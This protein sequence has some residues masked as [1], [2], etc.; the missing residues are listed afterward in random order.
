MWFPNWPIQRRLCLRPELRAN[1]YVLF[2][3]SARGLQI[4]ACSDI[5]SARGIRP[6]IPL[7]EARGLCEG[8]SRETSAT[9]QR[10]GVT[11]TLATDAMA[12][13]AMATNPSVT[14]TLV[15]EPTD[16]IA[17]RKALQ[18]LALQCQTYS[19]LVGVEESETPDSLLLE[20]TGCEAHFGGEQALA[21]QLWNE[22]SRYPYHA[23][24]AV[25]DTV[26]A[27]WAMAHFGDHFGVSGNHPVTVIPEGQHVHAIRTL[28]IAGL[29]LSPRI[30]ETLNKLDLRNI[31][32]LEKL[33]RTTLP[34]RFGKEL[35]RRLD[36]AWGIA[37]ELILPEHAPEPVHAV[38]NSEEPHANRE[39]LELVQRELLDQIL[40]LLQ[41][42]RL[43]IREL[44]CR[45]T[46]T[47]DSLTLTLRLVQP[48]L[49]QRHLWDLLRLEWERQE[50]SFLKSKL[51]APRCMTEGMTAIR[52]E[53]SITAPLKV[54]Q[55]TL[56]DLEPDQKQAQAFRQFVER[57]SSRLGSQA[58]LRPH[59]VP[60]AQPEYACEYAAWEEAGSRLALAESDAWETSLARSRPLRLLI[61]PEPLRV[62][63]PAS[64]GPPR[65]IWRGT[66]QLR[67]VR[68]WGPERIETGWWREH[69]VQRDYYRVETEQGQRLWIF[70]CQETGHWFL[71]GAY[72]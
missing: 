54:R 2:A 55:Q 30:L 66:Q 21:L 34:A 71:H 62:F 41:P 22:F 70:Q 64:D 49:D 5:A 44:Q 17:D 36:Q 60:D 59:P 13:D 56:F 27:A 37:H 23:R 68:T 11:E 63:S 26:G 3:E 39:T 38:W 9:P 1:A 47:V 52:L 28:P 10:H 51:P 48:S 35:L 25:A 16:P 14:D 57:L 53:A 7:A 43:G 58:V 8:S 65:R 19:P 50:R 20:I 42:Q 15:A 32:Q 18:Q 61:A 29:R 46:G 12:T 24:V 6:G 69:E 45:F 4:V 72:E 33:P 67:I 31:G 40:A